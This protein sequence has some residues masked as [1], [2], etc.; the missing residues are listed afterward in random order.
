MIETLGASR[1]QNPANPSV[2][3]DAA[4]LIE[5]ARRVLLQGLELLFEIGDRTYAR[6]AGAPFHATIGEHYH[7]VLELFQSVVRGARAGDISYN[8][9]PE[10][11]SRQQEEVRYASVATCDLLRALKPYTGEVLLRN[12]TVATN[13]ASGAPKPTPVESTVGRE[14]ASCIDEAV[15]HYG[16]IRLMSREFGIALP[17]EFG[18]CPSTLKYAVTLAS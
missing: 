18:V 16:I 4:E 7:N 1:I 11:N 10:R 9:C 17:E 12:C 14:L 15:H 3:T 6:R 13:A 2:S 8:V 5:A